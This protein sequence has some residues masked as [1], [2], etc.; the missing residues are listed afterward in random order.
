MKIRIICT[1]LAV[2]LSIP[3]FSRKTDTGL[4]ADPQQ[5]EPELK[6]DPPY[7]NPKL[8]VDERVKDLLQRM[9]I[10][11][12]FWQLFMIP[13][14]LDGGKEKYKNGIF[15]F[16]VSTKGSK[17]AA[18]QLLSYSP[19]NTALETARK[20][21]AIQHY[22]VAETRLGIP[23]IAF[24]EALHGLVR[25]GATAF[26]QSI[27][28]SA[29]WDTA[30]MG[31]VATAITRETKSRGIRQVLSPV[32]NIAADVRWG[33]TEETYGEDPFLSSAMGVAF[34]SAF[35]K[36]D[37]VTTPKHFIANSGDAGRDSYPAD[38]N[39][40]LLEDIYL[41]PFRAC[42]DQGGS[43]SVMT[44]YNALNGSPCTANDW[45]LNDKLKKQMKFTGFVISDACAVGGANVLHFTAAGYPEA[46][47]N[48]L[49]NG[50]DVIFQTDWEH[51]KLFIP[52]F[53]DGRISQ[54]NIDSA[55]AR[56]LR[57]KFQLGLFENPYVDEQEVSR[58]N[59]I[60][61]HKL[62]AKR[63]ALESIVLLKNT[64][65]PGR[66][67]PVLPLNK[68]IKSLAVIG[69]DAMEAR[70]GGYSGPGNG[71]IN[72]LDGI[73]QK[74]GNGCNVIYAPGCGRHNTDWVPVPSSNLM[75]MANGKPE[76]GVSGEYFN[77]VDLTGNPVLTRVDKEINFRWTLFSPHPDVNYDFYSVRWTGKLKAAATGNFKIGLDGNDGF[78]LYLDGKLVIDNWKK[79]GYSTLLTDYYFEKDKEYDLK[80]EFFESSGSVWLKLIW[81]IGI[82]NDWQA[83]IDEA[84]VAAGK[85]D[86]TIVVAGIEEGESLDRAFLN[87]PGHQEE[88]INR[89][90][91][92]G[93]PVVVVL[94]GGSAITMAKWINNV[95][96]IIDGWYPGEEG[97]HGMADVLFG[98]YNPAGRLPITFPVTEGQ[99]PLVYNHK[100]TGRTD[101]YSDLTGQP[102]FPFGFGLSYTSF[103]Y[104]DLE[105]DKLHL[106]K[107]ESALIHFKLKNTGNRDGDEVVQLYIRD[108]LSSVSRPVKELKGFQRI[109]L[110]AGEEKTV[111]FNLTPDLLEMLNDKMERIV[112]P[113]GFRIMIGASS[114]DIRLREI[115][116][117]KPDSVQQPE[118]AY[119]WPA[120]SAVSA[121]LHQWQDWK[122]GVIIHWGAY[123]Q[124][125]VV[126]SWSLCPEDEDWCI[127]R[128]PYANDYSRY[129][130]EYEKIRRS[131]NPEKFNP[132]HWAQAAREAGMKYVVFT[133]K[134]HDGFC[135]F[136]TK[137]TDYKITDSG[138]IFSHN[139]KSNVVKEVFNAFR[140]QGMGIGAYFSKPDWHSDDYWWPYFPVFDRNVNYDPAKYPERWKSFQKFTYNQ[141]EELMKDYGKVDILWLDG[142]Q[143]RPA[144]SLTEETK[145][146]LG[147]RQWIQDVD[148]PN[149]AGMARTYQPGMLIVDRTIHGEFENYRTPEQQI[150]ET[151]PAYPWES[152]I[153]LGDNWYSTGPGE[154]YKSVTWAIHTLIKIVAKGGNL[155]LGVGPDKTGEL[156][157]QV[158]ERLKGI[159]EWMKVNGEA[160]YNTRPLPPYQQ[161]N[162]CFTQSKDGKI[163]YI[164][165]L[166]KE[167][168]L[169]P[170]KIE[171]PEQLIGNIS[172]IG[173]LGNPKKLTIQFNNGKKIALIPESF[174]MQMASA[175]ALVFM[176]QT[177]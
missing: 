100:P 10:E 6:H 61:E 111:S 69:I 81:N 77:N 97:G 65:M 148:I 142:G 71:K 86:A 108:L 117:V 175:P 118:F 171:L 18:G 99:V 68:S 3:C 129:T 75:T 59:G 167:G 66:E 96:A 135:M 152:C 48:A 161:E 40:R 94:T 133:T 19:G 58:W 158:Y 103:E 114:N 43:R 172:Q 125:G 27:G 143:V 24:D 60:P 57:V 20:I 9:T 11:E 22:F 163:K 29:T 26:P 92:S 50:L 169:M 41:P 104:R 157:P 35:E 156:V 177:P 23:I 115:I 33:R 164:F 106:T 112:E 91:A 56:V 78:R 113:G 102:L 32:V 87:L 124:W 126:E 42:F 17:D 132:G 13:G 4:V 93:K 88:M 109:H 74:M 139:S 140:Q 47:A 44:S 38:I 127:R 37:V 2:L 121:R 45:L 46:S 174:R 49:N 147:R 153:T 166:Q 82:T 159:G 170:E 130:A 105:I 73:K 151:I 62:A 84:M 95:G 144:G 122:F 79:Q 149:I 131:F 36:L 101:D 85:A 138:S 155:L 51:Y 165:C 146:W 70:L 55:V 160:I 5:Q 39:E 134:H 53:L 28:L 67:E 34:V 150:P 16:Q 89:I 141:I 98:D 168:E 123:S 120:D 162:F 30:L 80:V 137:Y 72:I 31:L 1:F 128:G 7:K 173:L 12:K 145:T 176:V 54:K 76:S 15:G 8:T 90:A 25:D 136:D 119:Q 110:D 83:K 21:N 116:E 14:D 107:N 64:K 154:R 63:A 52:P